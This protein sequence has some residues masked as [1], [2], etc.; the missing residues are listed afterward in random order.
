MT[1]SN[2][3][4]HKEVKKMNLITQNL[5][6]QLFHAIDNGKSEI[7]I[8]SPYISYTTVNK[9]LDTYSSNDVSIKVITTFDRQNF[10]DGASSLKALKA[11]V[12]FNVEVFA[13]QKLH[14]KLYIIDRKVCFVG[15]ANF[16]HSGLNH[17]HE[18]LIK[19]EVSNQVDEL[20]TYA[21]YLL[22]AVRNWT[23]SL[24]KIELEEEEIQGMQMLDHKSAKSA[25]AWGAIIPDVNST[26]ERVLSVPAGK[27]FDIVDRYHIHAHP[28]SK[29]YNYAKTNYIS[30][31]QS[32]GGAMKSIFTIDETFLINMEDWENEIQK[33]QLDPLI[34]IQLT[35]YINERMDGL[36]FEQASIYKFYH[37]KHYCSLPNH[38]HPERN[39]PG[40]WYYSL[41]ELL[42][43]DGIVETM[44]R[45]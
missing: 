20:Y 8:I 26:N 39:N 43:S 23:I 31:R 11:L 6:Q 17:N 10:M 1:T 40:G 32:G 33:L 15:S 29:S 30:F 16:T 12:N 34:K 42:T 9:L 41:N 2:I 36:K 37:L 4:R 22:D 38:P 7:I 18:L 44:N 25:I 5:E 27:T 13:L 24:D 28:D 3:K 35:G 14:T 21:S 19:Y 45:H